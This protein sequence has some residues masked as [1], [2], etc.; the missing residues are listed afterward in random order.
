MVYYYLNKKRYAIDL[1]F[2]EK[3]AVQKLKNRINDVFEKP[4]LTK[5]EPQN[6]TLFTIGYEGISIDKYIQKLLQN[7][8][9]T[10]VDVRQNAY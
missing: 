8:I 10:L 6:K 1:T 7:C 2:D 9:K 5:N 4:I 3:T